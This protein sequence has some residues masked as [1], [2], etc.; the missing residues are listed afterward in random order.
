MGSSVGSFFYDFASLKDA[1][2]KEHFDIIYEAGYTS[3]VP[4]YIWFNVK[5]INIP[6]LRL[7]WMAWNISVLNSTNGYR[8]FI[9][10][11]RTYYRET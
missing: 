11:G 1:L 2:K 5:K 8:K 3:I 4:A 10:L 6:Y 7:I 9:F